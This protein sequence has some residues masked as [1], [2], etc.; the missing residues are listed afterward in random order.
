[1]YSQIVCSVDN[2]QESFFIL[3]FGLTIVEED[4]L[5]YSLN[6]EIVYEKCLFIELT[7]DQFGSTFGEFCRLS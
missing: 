4:F 3:K 7:L 1:M 2:A 6:F 5:V